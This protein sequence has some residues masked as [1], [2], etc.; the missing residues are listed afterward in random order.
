MSK[1]IIQSL[2]I[3]D[4]LSLLEQLCIASFIYHGHE[5]HLYTYEKVA[6]VPKGTILRNANDIIPEKDIFTYYNGSYAGFADWFRWAL[7]YAQGNFYV[8]MDV[9]CIKPFEFNTK[10]VYGFQEERT[11]CSAV[12]G[13]PSKHEL[14]AFL[15]VSCR[16]PNL[17]LPYDNMKSKLRKIIRKMIHGNKRQSIGWGESGGPHGL[18]RAL[19]YFGL[20]DLAKPYTYFYPIHFSCWKKIFYETHSKDNQLF[21]DTYAIHLW[22]ELGRVARLDKNAS[23]PKDS[24]IELLKTKYL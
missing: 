13:F 6:N 2:W 23:F 24:L 18:T 4:K 3:G 22:N 1:P 12:L 19:K 16:Q 7:L 10:L 21:S 8:D 15:E 11:I 14:P 9:V 17:I 20:I 5:F